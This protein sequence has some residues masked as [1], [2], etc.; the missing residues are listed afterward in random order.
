MT[1]AILAVGLSMFGGYE[2]MA[3]HPLGVQ[4]G[5]ET[6][7]VSYIADPSVGHGQFRLENYGTAAVMAS[8]TSAW[9]ELGTHRQPL[10][11]IT[12]YNLDHEQTLDPESFRVD[13]GATMRFLIG[14]PEF[15]Y[16]PHFG[17]STAVGLRLKVHG[18]EIQALS[19]VK[20]VRRH[21]RESFTDRP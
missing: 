5:G 18:A 7:T 10:P 1:A 21:P 3:I 6:V 4:L 19:P 9:L 8:V 15:A 11:A 17:E 12:V 16:E 20:F 14:F 2:M 13:A